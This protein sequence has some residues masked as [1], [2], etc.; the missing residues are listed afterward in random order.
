MI[1]RTEGEVCPSKVVLIVVVIWKLGVGMDNL[2][3]V[4]VRGDGSQKLG[5]L[6]MFYNG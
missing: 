1:V 3:C 2:D 6:L 5:G 4:E